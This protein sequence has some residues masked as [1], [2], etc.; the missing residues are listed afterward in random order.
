MEG[1]HAG[2]RGVTGAVGI[3]AA[4]DVVA[5]GK[6]AAEPGGIARTPEVEMQIRCG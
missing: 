1:Q 4:E 5:S 3:E 2:G 6:Q